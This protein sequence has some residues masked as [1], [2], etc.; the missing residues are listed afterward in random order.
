M[1][2]I[3]SGGKDGSLTPLLRIKVTNNTIA[4]NWYDLGYEVLHKM[5]PDNC[6]TI[7]CN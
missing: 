4:A 2:N 7:V 3:Q 1:N 6:G 5:M